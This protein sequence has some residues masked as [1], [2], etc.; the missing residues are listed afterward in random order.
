MKWEICCKVKKNIEAFK[1]FCDKK[2]F[3]AGLRVFLKKNEFGKFVGILTILPN[4]MRNEFLEG[5]RL[6]NSWNLGVQKFRYHSDIIPISYRRHTET[7]TWPNFYGLN[8]FGKNV[9]KHGLFT[10]CTHY[11]LYKIRHNCD[12]TIKTRFKHRNSKFIIFFCMVW[13]IFW[14]CK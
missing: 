12:G 6:A 9:Q 11:H 10:A 2:I 8:P 3:Q 4:G 1:Q 5:E 13:M 7:P 14:H